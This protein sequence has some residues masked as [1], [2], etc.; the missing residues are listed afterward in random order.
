MLTSDAK[1]SIVVISILTPLST[2]F[3]GLRPAKKRKVL[4]LD[5]WLL[6]CAVL[7]LWLQYVGNCL[8]KTAFYYH[9]I[10][11][12]TRASQWPLK[13]ARRRSQRAETRWNQMAGE[14][15]PLWQA[16]KVSRLTLTNM[17]Y[18]PELG[19]TI[20]VTI[21]K[22][23]V[24]LSYNRIFGR[25]KWFRYSLISVGSLTVA[26]F[27]GVFF[28]FIFQ[29]KPI[30]KAWNPTKPGHCIAFKPFVWGNSI[31]NSILD[32]CVLLLLVV[33]VLKLQMAPVQKMLLLG[34]FFL[35]SL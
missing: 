20:C 23:S 6:C 16:N 13:A 9:D 22:I 34:T 21:I 33:P 27:I 11:R 24:L 14:G 7:L 35:G 10:L 30:D 17:K 29:C 32:Y 1:R 18:W 28:S 2:L 12:L 26:W 15:A 25:L 19:Y 5:D 8:Y 4:G 3:L 31:S